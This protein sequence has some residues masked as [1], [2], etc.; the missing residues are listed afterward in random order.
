DRLGDNSLEPVISTVLQILRR[1]HPKRP[2]PLVTAS[3]ANA[4]PVPGDVASEP[5][6]ALAEEDF[7]DDSDD[8]EEDK[9]S[10]SEEVKEEDDDLETDVNKLSC[11]PGLDRPEGELMQYAAMCP[12]LSCS[13]EELERNPGGN[14]NPDE[15]QHANHRHIP[16]DA[17]SERHCLTRDQ[18]S[19][20]RERE[21]AVQTSLLSTVKW[22]RSTGHLASR[23]G[24]GLNP[25]RSTQSNGPGMDSSGNETLDT[26]AFLKEDAWDMDTI[27]CPKTNA[28]FPNSTRCRGSVEVMDKLLQAHPK[29]VPFHDPY[30]YMAKARGTR[31]VADLKTVAF[32]DLWGHCLSSSPQPLLERKCGIQ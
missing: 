21:D 15:M 25:S 31:S 24:H 22:G 26:Q 27:S 10:D 20:G 6:R 7:E 9:D 1:C 16:A 17:S 5:P 4:F 13:F 12:E 23:K 14:L 18:S 28:S 29:H 30:L 2:L 19:R 32:P 8:E 11:K 3:S